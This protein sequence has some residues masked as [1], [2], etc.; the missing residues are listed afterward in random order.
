VTLLRPLGLWY[1]FRTYPQGRLTT[2]HSFDGAD[3]FDPFSGLLQATDGTFYGTTQQGGSDNDGTVFRLA[4]GLLPFVKTLPTS[5]TVRT[6][7][8]IL[9]NHLT[10]ATGVFFNGIPAAFKVVS[11]T[12]IMTTVPSGATTGKVEVKT[13]SGTLISNVNFR[14]N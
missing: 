10:D 1:S 13:S 5:G 11:S 2:L 6:A 3:G 9:G 14:V 12:E 7:V 4:V 8:I